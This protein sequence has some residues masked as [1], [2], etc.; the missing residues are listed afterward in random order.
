MHAANATN[1]E[2][3][4]IPGLARCLGCIVS[5]VLLFLA[6]SVESGGAQPPFK[7]SPLQP[8]PQERG[9]GEGADAFIDRHALKTPRD[10]EASLDRLVKHLAGP[11]RGDRE[12]ARALF[13]WMTDRI[14]Y[15]V[16]AF[17]TGHP[18]EVRPAKVF[19]DRKGT[20]YGITALFETMARRAGLEAATVLGHV[21]LVLVVGPGAEARNSIGIILVAGMIVGTLFTLFVVPVFYSLIAARHAPAAPEGA[22][23]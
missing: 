2:Q 23:A 13:R 10:V 18:G 6:A 4:A 17:L 20:C 16:D 14:H 5:M 9:T 8:I 7:F 11:A 12:I 19:Q 15:D 22:E 21:P 1:R 3:S